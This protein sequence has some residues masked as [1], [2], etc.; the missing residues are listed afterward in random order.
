V[1]PTGL[2][3]FFAEILRLA[4]N[5]RGFV[6]GDGTALTNPIHEADAARACVDALTLEEQ[7]DLPVGGPVTYTRAEIVELAFRVLGRSPSVRNVPAWMMRPIPT[8]MRIVNRR[9]AALVEFGIAVS[10]SDCI[11]PVYGHLTLDSYFREMLASNHQW[12]SPRQPL[13]SSATSK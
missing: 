4:A 8:M 1:R 9:I 3:S 10:Q 12:R 13:T 11:A 5:N 7:H 2:F 6:V